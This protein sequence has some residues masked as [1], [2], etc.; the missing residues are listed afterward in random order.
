MM[1]ENGRLPNLEMKTVDLHDKHVH[2]SI[3]VQMY[4][5]HVHTL[6]H[7]DHT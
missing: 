2:Y 4:N 7:L 5:V 3:V 1:R 6:V